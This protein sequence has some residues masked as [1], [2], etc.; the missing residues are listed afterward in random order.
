MKIELKANTSNEKL[1]KEYLEKNAD[2]TLALKINTGTKTLKGCW[3]YIVDEARKQAIGNCAVIQDQEVFGWAVHYF[4]EDSIKEN[5]NP[6]NDV[7][8]T[9]SKEKAKPETKGGS[10]QITL[11]D[12]DGGNHGGG[13][14]QNQ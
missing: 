6:K 11:F 4:E 8:V 14:S 12:F 2:A 10:G 7:K 9:T 5:N 3:N 13:T 1:V